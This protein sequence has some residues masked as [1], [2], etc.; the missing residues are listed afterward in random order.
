[1]GAW[2]AGPFQN[3]DASD[4]AL[5]LA[6]AGSAVQ[7]REA[8]KARSAEYLEAPEGSIILAAAE[9]VAAALGQPGGDLPDG[10][11][12]WLAAHGSEVTAD[13]A[14]IALAAIDR[15]T[16][17]GSELRELWDE[18]GVDTWSESIAELRQRL[19]SLER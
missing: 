17:D 3:D 7:V 11:R 6:S 19:A 2:G 9:F 13:D 1:M 12:T 5:D 8:L 15:V 10:V 16:G 4:W 18:S 14:T